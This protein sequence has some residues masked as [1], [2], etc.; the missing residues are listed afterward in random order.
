MLIS[1]SQFFKD[2]K[3]VRALVFGKFI[4]AYLHQIALEITLLLVNN[5][6]EKRITDTQD[7]RHFGSERA[8]Y[9]LHSCYNFA[10]ELH[11]NALVFSQSDARTFSMSI[12]HCI[13]TV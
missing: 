1:T 8:I 13:I 5:L 10:L 3:I 2:N 11:E 7:R 9:N 4:S 12:T 6:H